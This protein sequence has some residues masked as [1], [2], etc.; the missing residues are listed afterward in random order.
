MTV[1]TLVFFNNLP[2]E[3]PLQS[4][5]VKHSSGGK[6]SLMLGSHLK[7]WWW[8]ATA[9]RADVPVLRQAKQRRWCEI[10]NTSHW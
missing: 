5:R 10:P 2:S 3:V 9:V 8:P 4:P 1:N 7:L 6:P